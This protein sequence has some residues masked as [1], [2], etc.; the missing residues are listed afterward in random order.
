[1][2]KKIIYIGV[3]IA[4]TAGAAYSYERVR[5]GERTVVFF[6]WVLA[7]ESDQRS[8]RGRGRFDRR[9]ELPPDSIRAQSDPETRR[10]TRP[11]QPEGD[12]EE[13]EWP[14][15]GTREISWDEMRQS[16]EDMPEETRQRFERFA[17]ERGDEDSRSA[18]EF[19]G[20]GGRRG[21]GSDISLRE[22]AY[23]ALILSFATMATYWVDQVARVA[24]RARQRRK[25]T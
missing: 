21:R 19:R 9:R 24:T 8:S 2:V 18:R 7:D 1:M 14:P 4:L 3:A 13:V 22:V 16:F 15:R 11:T 20:R 25:S 10:R 6:R 12:G 23:Y 5:F 17:Q